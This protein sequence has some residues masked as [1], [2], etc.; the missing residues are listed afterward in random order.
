ML[1]PSVQLQLTNRCNLAC[2]YCCTN[3]GEP[4]AD[5]L[6]YEGW[7]EVVD[8]ALEVAGPGVGIAILGGEP[9]LA[10]HALDLGAHILRRGGK[11]TV[12]TNGMPLARSEIAERV[13]RL[14][15]QGASVRVSLAGATRGVCDGASGAQ[16]FDTVVAGL[17]ALAAHGAR[18]AVDLM[19]LPE[20]VDDVA[21]NLPA[22]RKLLPEG[23]RVC[24]GLAYCGGR[25]VGAHVFESRAA[26]EA[27]L[28]R[29][30]FEAGEVVPAAEPS[31]LTARRDACPCALGSTLHV[32]SDGRLF[33]C[34]KME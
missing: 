26:L 10:E 16:R 28:D 33:T 6:D 29:V 18:V 3:S 20:H 5:E 14:T 19:L 32:R 8:Q 27:A 1:R 22:L 23:T 9:L 13:A 12:F 2:T 34:F 24:L 11:L 7:T 21:R 15:E 30:A 4:R 31:P 17:R 25:E